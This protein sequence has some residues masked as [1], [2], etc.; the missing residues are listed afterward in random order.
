MELDSAYSEKFNIE[1]S[2]FQNLENVHA[3]PHI[4][5]YWS[6]KYFLPKIKALG[7]ESLVGFF[8]HYLAEG[9]HR[10]EGTTSKILSL[11]SGNCD[12]ELNLA[13]QL[14]EQNT[15]NFHFV[16]LEM[17][18]AMLERG[19]ALAAASNLTEHF[20]FIECDLNSWRGKEQFD[21]ILAVHSLH[22]VVAL[23]G[24]F[25][26]VHRC[27]AEEG[28]FLI[29]DMI[30]RNGHMRWPEA[31]QVVQD[32]WK[33]LPHAQKYNYQL[34]R[35]EEEYE[36]WDC[37]TEGFEGVRAQEILP[38]LIKRFEFDCF[39]GFSNVADIFVD[40]C[41]GPNFNPDN[42]SDLRFIDRV[43]EKDDALIESGEIKPT[44]MMAALRTRGVTAK[45]YK[46]LT[47][48][49]CVRWP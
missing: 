6:Q 7:F 33:E 47:P 18:G 32:F 19:A 11:G 12:F 43:A 1:L 40:R 24:L 36:N 22:H 28:T 42:E 20:S 3:L 30:G 5:H 16:C 46:H 9:C 14:R 21:S 48:G 17:N 49:F 8:I 45:T 39:L 23:E 26:E 13:G 35:F 15:S 41:F 34:R 29:H 2:N 4:Y 31:L 37:S 27:L 44:H 38:E 10:R 25:D